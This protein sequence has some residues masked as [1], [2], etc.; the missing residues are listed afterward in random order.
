MTSLSDEEFEFFRAIVYRETGIKLTDLK[1]SLLQSRLM[2]RM[3]DLHL[4]S[5]SDYA[6]Y[7]QSSYSEE[8]IN[9]I[10]AITTN[11]TEFFREE[12]HFEILLSSILP[13]FDSKGKRSLRI[14]SA[15][16]STGEEP[17]SI[18]M[19]LLRHYGNLGSRDVRILATDIDTQVLQKGL[20]G[21]Y[22]SDQVA[23]MDPSLIRNY[24]LPNR[25]GSFRIIEEAQKIIT[26]KRL[27]LLDAEYPMKKKFNCIFC[28]NVIIYFDKPTQR[29]LF[30]RFN[31]Y[32]EDDGYLFVG[33]SE[34]LS[35]LSD[36]FKLIG[37]TVY[38]KA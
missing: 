17:Y 27:N 19:T 8:I 28:R 14:W 18:A 9:F 38:K 31:A 34:N 22:K 2:R 6:E 13:E 16:C 32:L 35:G 15:G 37:R 7:V 33:H 1:R 26:F 21:I 24:F 36:R 20:A 23:D 11:K 4:S 12:Q 25:D 30:E 10:N 5:F 29:A 3:R